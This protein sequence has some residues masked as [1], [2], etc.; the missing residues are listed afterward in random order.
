LPEGVGR[1]LAEAVGDVLA[2]AELRAST[3]RALDTASADA[4]RADVAL[5]VLAAPRLLPAVSAA[6]ARLRH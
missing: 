5:A 3:R 4:A 1:C 2:S 6:L